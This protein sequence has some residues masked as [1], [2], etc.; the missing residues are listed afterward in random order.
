MA[1][2]LVIFIEGLSFVFIFNGLFRKEKRYPNWTI[3][4]NLK[5]KKEEKIS[6]QFK[7][8]NPIE[9]FSSNDDLFCI[10]YQTYF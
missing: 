2:Y 7:P 1:N 3:I 9:P 10:K 5:R 4:K 6:S 8:I